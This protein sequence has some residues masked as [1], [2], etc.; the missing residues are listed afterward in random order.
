MKKALL[1]VLMIIIAVLVM[2]PMFT[3]SA[4]H[5]KILGD[6]DGDGVVSI[7]DVTAI[8]LHLADFNQIAAENVR[9]ADV[10]GNGAIEIDDASAIQRYLAEYVDTYGIGFAL[11]E[12][13][14]T[15]QTSTTNNYELPFVPA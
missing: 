8:Q 12:T 7:T 5:K 10:D 9:S 11:E 13:A 6:A 14:S 4:E 1:P 2:I 15:A 3:A